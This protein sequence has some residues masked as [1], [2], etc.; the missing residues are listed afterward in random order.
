MKLFLCLFSIYIL[1]L[2]GI[3]CQAGDD[4][5]TDGI[6]ANA[7]PK[8]EKSS[9]CSPFFACGSCHGFV[10]PHFDLS[11][12]EHRPGPCVAQAFYKNQPLPHFSSSIWQPPK[13]A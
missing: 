3:P 1:V 4:C 7:H 9:P 12:P 11:L 10:I 6:S 5:C 13:V 8:Q 2:A